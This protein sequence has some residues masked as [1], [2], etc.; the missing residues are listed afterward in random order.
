[1]QIPTVVALGIGLAG[2]TPLL[3]A[4]VVVQMLHY[5]AWLGAPW[6]TL[7]RLWLYWPWSVGVW[8][9]RYAW[10]YPV[11]FDWAASVMAGW[12]LSVAVLVACLLKRAGWRRVISPPDVDWARPRE[13]R[14]AH[15]FVKVRK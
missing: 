6:W 10:Y 7:G 1:M 9:W 5:P 11:P 8:W 3:G 13:I 4:Q 14:K 2:V 12:I 15:F